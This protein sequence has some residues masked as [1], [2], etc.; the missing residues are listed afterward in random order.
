MSLTK[1]EEGSIRELWKISFPLMLNSFSVMFMLFIDRLLLAKFSTAAFNA[2]VNATTLGWGFMAAWIVLAGIAEV[3]VAQYNGAGEKNKLGEPVWQMI[4]LSL[5]SIFFFFPMSF[6]GPEFFY[7]AGNQHYLEKQYFSIMMLFAPV[8]PLYSALCSFYIGQGKTL[9]ITFLSLA[10]NIVNAILDYILIFGIEGWI[11]S[12]GITGAAIATSIGGVFE[13]VVLGFCFLSEKTHETFGTR[14]YSFSLTSMWQC[15]KVGLPGAV[16]VGIEIFGWACFYLIMTML[17]ESYITI[18]GICQSVAIL[19]FFLAEGISKAVTA[20]AGNLIGA[21]RAFIIDKVLYSGFRL[22][23]L[24]FFGFLFLYYLSNDFVIRQFMS[25]KDFA[26][27]E[28]RSSAAICLFFMIVYLLF[29][30]IR[31]LYSGI[32]TAA[33]DTYFLLVAG[34]LSVW[35]LMVLPNYLLMIGEKANIEWYIGTWIFYSILAAAIYHWRYIKG[36]WQTMVIIQ[37]RE[38]ENLVDVNV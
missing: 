15:I 8:F 13:V 25:D 5:A 20:I 7:G 14:N 36:H 28:L 23:I 33:G 17:G 18:A 35:V 1:Y 31:M 2:A 3:F 24:F 16:F 38:S 10:A 34:S 21:K 29:E 9:L 26:S 32:L 22:H 6:W 11:P 4:W 19:F 30:G 12:L 37:N 27:I